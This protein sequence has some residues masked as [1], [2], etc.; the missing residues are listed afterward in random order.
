[1]G[2]CLAFA[3]AGEG[4]DL[5]WLN[6]PVGN[7]AGDV[8]DGFAWAFAVALIALFVLIASDQKPLPP[9]ARRFNAGPGH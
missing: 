1:M 9:G 2:V 4:V 8:A 5:A 3:L 7:I 6:M